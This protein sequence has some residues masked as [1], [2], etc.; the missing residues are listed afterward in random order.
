[1]FNVWLIS[2][3]SPIYYE[4]INYIPTSAYIY[5]IHL[6]K[7]DLSSTPFIMAASF[8]KTFK[9]FLNRPL[10]ALFFLMNKKNVVIVFV[11][12]E[13]IVYFI[14]HFT[15]FIIPLCLNTGDRTVS[16]MTE[17]DIYQSFEIYRE[18]RTMLTFVPSTKR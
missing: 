2:L 4:Y 9:C 15:L 18:R 3:P 12:Y 14:L 6:K 1:M 5:N 17:S 7:K 16:S 8:I 10:G 13:C 11:F